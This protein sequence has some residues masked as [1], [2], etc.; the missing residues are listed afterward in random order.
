METSEILHGEAP[1]ASEYEK[2]LFKDGTFEFKGTPEESEK[3][4]KIFDEYVQQTLSSEP[5]KGDPYEEFR[6]I[7]E[8]TP[9]EKAQTQMDNARKQQAIF[10][11]WCAHFSG[12]V[13]EHWVVNKSFPKMGMDVDII[14]DVENAAIN[15]VQ[16]SP[17]LLDAVVTNPVRGMLLYA[18][19]D[20]KLNPFQLAFK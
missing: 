9:E 1:Q 15:N 6:K 20:Q 2:G 3:Y 4:K 13:P 18:A 12:K 8:L 5:P 10:D 16:L 7:Q 17:R 11:A 14:T 19:R